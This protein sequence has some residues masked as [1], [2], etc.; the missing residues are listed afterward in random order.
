MRRSGNWP[1]V[2]IVRGAVENGKKTIN[3]PMCNFAI[4]LKKVSDANDPMKLLGAH[5]EKFTIDEIK[6]SASAL[7]WTNLNYEQLFFDHID[8]HVPGD[9]IAKFVQMEDEL[10]NANAGIR[11]YQ[12]YLRASLK[13][14]PNNLAAFEDHLKKVEKETFSS[15]FPEEVNKR[16]AEIKNWGPDR[17]RF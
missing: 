11:F 13:A 17:P 4:V 5:S 8:S 2:G 14:L 9:I 16:L 7:D 6:D 15:E 1:S 3:C 10:A 12:D